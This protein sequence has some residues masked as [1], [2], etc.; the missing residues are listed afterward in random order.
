MNE[1][2]KELEGLEFETDAR[3]SSKRENF[4]PDV[5]AQVFNRK[6]KSGMAAMRGGDVIERNVF[7][8]VLDGSQA[9]P[10]FFVDEDGEYFDVKIQIRSLNSREEVAALQGVTDGAQVP[11]ALARACVYA[12][13]GT[14]LDEAQREF[15]WEGLG[16]R[17]RQLALLAFNMLGGASQAALGKFR[18]SFSVA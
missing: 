16:M 4:A 12:L 5:M 15:L 11:F 3:P 9:T 6:T 10:A 18:R 14:P 8:F 7:E 1:E 13:N 2:E 17:G